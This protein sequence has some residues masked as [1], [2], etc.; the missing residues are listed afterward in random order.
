MKYRILLIIAIL[1]VMQS[2]A[3]PNPDS[4]VITSLPYVQDFSTTVDGFVP[5]WFRGNNT[6]YPNSSIYVNTYSTPRHLYISAYLGGQ[7]V[8]LPDIVAVGRSMNVTI[9]VSLAEQPLDVVFVAIISCTFEIGKLL[10]TI[11]VSTRNDAEV[12]M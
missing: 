1:S 10:F 5:C 6:P 9:I 4:C 7:Y 12:V 8:A 11:A 2:F 3:Q